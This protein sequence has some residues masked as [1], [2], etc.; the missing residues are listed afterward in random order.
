MPSKQD[1]ATGAAASRK[2]S[3]ASLPLTKHR[4]LRGGPSERPSAASEL[5]ALLLFQRGCKLQRGDLPGDYIHAKEG[6]CEG[7]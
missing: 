1:S 4:G 3:C 7:G 6:L 5:A 2:F